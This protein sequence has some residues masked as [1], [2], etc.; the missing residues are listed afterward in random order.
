MRPLLALPLIAACTTA[1]ESGAW[2]AVLVNGGGASDVN[3]ASHRDHLDRV[4]DAL[5]TRGFAVDQ[6]QVLASDGDDP[7]PDLLSVAK[8]PD[9]GSIPSWAIGSGPLF[10]EGGPLASLWPAPVLVDTSWTRTAVGPATVDALTKAVRD[11]GLTAGDTLLLYTTDHG[12]PDGSLSLWYESL[13]PSGIEAVLDPLPEGARAL[14]VMSQCHSGAFARPLLALRQAGQDVCGTFSVPEDRQ[15]TGCFPERD[16][17]P[18][19]HGFRVGEAFARSADFDAM[20]RHL[21]LADQGPDVPLRT[22][23]VYLWDRLV[24]EADRRGED[25]VVTVDR[26]LAQ[27]HT[28]QSAG[29]QATIAALSRRA[30]ITPPRRLA[31][32]VQHTEQWTEAIGQAAWKVEDLAW[33]TSDAVLRV[34]QV[35]ERRSAGRDDVDWSAMLGEAAEHTGLS[36]TLPALQSAYRSAET[37]LWHWT[38]REALVARMGW[39]LSRIAG[40]ALVGDDPELDALL[41]CEGARLGGTAPVAAPA[42]DWMVEGPVPT[43]SAVPWMGIRLDRDEAGHP[44]VLA[45]HPDSPARGVL[46]PGSRVIAVDGAP[47][48]TVESVVSRFALSAVGRPLQIDAG[49]GPHG[50]EPVA[51]PELLLPSVVPMDGDPAPDVLRWVTDKPAGAH[52]IVWTGGQCPSCGSALQRSRDWAA[53]AGHRLVHI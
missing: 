38:V 42:A 25:I 29:T 39:L 51:W 31:E 41:S 14:V 27:A 13:P 9:P 1:P 36:S 4:T 10:D 35:A 50:V 30:G 24:D 33:V 3:Y 23:D 46:E 2:R 47:T 52:L 28:E 15:A 5:L 45:L 44:L 48:P 20:H 53:Q 8:M 11:A 21:V 43:M 16:G 22:S 19:G 49:R 34:Q 37:E 32:L 18:I 26:L 7:T 17:A 6:I 40:R 12:E